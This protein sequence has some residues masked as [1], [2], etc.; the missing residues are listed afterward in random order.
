[1]T[2]R[3]KDNGPQ[4]GTELIRRVVLTGS[5]AVFIGAYLAAALA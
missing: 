3:T 5:V 1:M 2:L 4:D